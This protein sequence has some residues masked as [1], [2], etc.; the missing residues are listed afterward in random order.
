M[1]TT[2][3]QVLERPSDLRVFE[4]I[5]ADNPAITVLQGKCAAAS[6]NLRATGPVGSGPTSQNVI[7][8]VIVHRPHS[9]ELL[10]TA[11]RGDMVQI[12]GTI[13]HGRIVVPLQDGRVDMFFFDEE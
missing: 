11:S 13:Q 5:L 12:T 10:K 9:V 4:G 2:I 3:D 1:P 6:F 8:P 7:W